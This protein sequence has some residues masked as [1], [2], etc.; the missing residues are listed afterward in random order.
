MVG[1]K[2]SAMR[3][4]NLAAAVPGYMVHCYIIKALK[5]KEMKDKIMVTTM[6]K[7]LIMLSEKAK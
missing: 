3:I 7:V 4:G 6:Q 2:A 1:Y 5:S